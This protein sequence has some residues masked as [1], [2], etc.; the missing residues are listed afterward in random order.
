MTKIITALIIVGALFVGW[1]VFVYWDQVKNEEEQ[2]AKKAA[3]A[4]HVVPQELAGMPYQMESSLD[5]ATKLGSTGLRNWLKVYGPSIQD[6][7]KAWIELDFCT[8]VSR[9]DISEAR[10]VF[11]DVKAR[12]P[13]SS[14]IYPRIRQLEKT[15]Q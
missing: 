11:A 9:E 3:R 15:F 10:R 2:A 1:Q 8:M 4:A 7:R 13:Q 5:A 14:P 6:P 12:T